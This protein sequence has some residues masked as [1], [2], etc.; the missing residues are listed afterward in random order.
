VRSQIAEIYHLDPNADIDM[1]TRNIS[2]DKREQA[3]SLG[4]ALVA[5]GKVR[6]KKIARFSIGIINPEFEPVTDDA[7]PERK[8]L[9]RIREV[10]YAI[11]FGQDLVPGR[12]YFAHWNGRTSGEKPEDRHTISSLPSNLCFFA[13]EYSDRTD[14]CIPMELKKELRAK[15]R[16]LPEYGLWYCGFSID[17]NDVMSF[18]IEPVSSPGVQDKRKKIDIPLERFKDLFYMSKDG[19]VSV[20]AV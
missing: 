2:A 13:V 1:R 8:K 4:A 3:I 12:P 16:E 19:E 17:E 6:L 20:D 9:S 14:Q 11:H 10:Y 5:A 7:D 18:H 15:L